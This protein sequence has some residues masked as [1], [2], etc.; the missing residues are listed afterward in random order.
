MNK[1]ILIGNL[2]KDPEASSTQS[3]VNFTRFTIAVNRPFTNASGE[4]VADYFDIIA[5]PQSIC[6]RVIK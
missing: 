2:T 5:W 6:L 3:G 4:R 1:I